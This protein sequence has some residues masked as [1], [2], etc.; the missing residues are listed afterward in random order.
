MSTE[1]WRIS[2]DAGVPDDPEEFI[3]SKVELSNDNIW[4]S[5]FD[6]LV[7]GNWFHLESMD[8]NL[9]YIRVGRHSGRIT[10]N[11][12]EGAVIHWEYETPYEGNSE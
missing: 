12:E 1:S 4:R 2:I 7:I 6:E 5:Q 9:W 10:N 8:D 11:T 3:A